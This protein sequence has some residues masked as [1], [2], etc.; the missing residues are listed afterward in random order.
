LAEHIAS[1]KHLQPVAAPQSASVATKTKGGRTPAWKLDPNSP[2]AIDYLGKLDHQFEE[3]Q[4]EAALVLNR[5]IVPVHRY[6]MAL[7]GFSANMSAAEASAL[8]SVPGVVSVEK[9]RLHRIHTDA[10]PP[11]IGAPAIWNGEGFI[12]ES[13]GEGIVV[14]IIDTGINWE[15]GSFADTGENGGYDYENPYPGQLG[16]CSEEEVECNDKLVGVWDFVEDDPDTDT[17]E[18]FNNGFDNVNH[19]TLVAHITAGNPRGVVIG[20]APLTLTGVAQRAH[21][22]SYR[23]C[24]VGDP[25]EDL[26]QGSAILKAI[27]QAID[28]GVDVINYSIGSGAFSP[29]TPGSTARAFL[30]A[31]DAG[32]FVATSS[33]NDG[34]A[35]YTVGSPGNAPW[36]TAVGSATHDRLLA[37]IVKATNG[38]DTTPPGDLY[39]TSFVSEGVSLTDIVHAKDFGFPLCGTGPDEDGFSCDDNTGASNPWEPGTFNGEIVVCDRGTYGRVEKGKNLMLAGAGGYILANTSAHG[40]QIDTDSHC[41]P[42]SHIGAEDADR[43]RDWLDSGDGHMGSIT[44]FTYINR[45][46]VADRLSWF[47]SR[48]P[49]L[50]PVQNILKPDIIAPGDLIIGAGNEGQ[51]LGIA[52]GTSFSSPHV[53][54]AAAL[55]KSLDTSMTPSMLSSVLVTTSTMELAKDEFDNPGTPHQFGGG[56]PQLGEAAQAGVYFR[57]TTGRFL[58]ANPSA[59]GNP[60]TLNLPTMTNAECIETCSFT[61]TVRPLVNNRTWTASTEGFPEGVT[62]TVT[63]NQFVLGADASQE[64]TVDVDLGGV[65]GQWVFG[66]VVLSANN[67]PSAEL[68]VTVM[69]PA[70]EL[71][72]QWT[73]A[74]NRDSGWKSFRL[75]GL[76]G[77]PEA[78]YK[79]SGLVAPTVYSE[80]LEEDPTEGDPYDEGEGVFTEIVA[81]PQGALWLHVQTLESDHDDLDLYVG[82]DDNGN[83]KADPGEER[84]FSA[85]PADLEVCDVMSPQPGNWWVLTQVWEDT[86]DLVNCHEDGGPECVEAEA[87]VGVAVVGGD[88]SSNFNATGP[89]IVPAGTGFDVRLSW[90]DINALTDTTLFGAVSLG[91][92]QDSPGNLGVVPV[93]FTRSGLGAPRTLALMDGHTHAFAVGKNKTY[94]KAFIDVPM[95]ATSLDVVVSG[96]DADQNDRLTLELH[97]MPFEEAFGD[98]PF[99]ADLPLPGTPAGSET[100]SGG[101]GPSVTVS[102]ILLE[103]GRWYAVVTS[104]G[105]ASSVEL[106]AT[107]TFAGNPLPLHPGVWFPFSR[108]TISQGYDYS[109]GGGDTTRVMIWYTYGDDHNSTWYLGSN[110]TPNGNIWTADVLRFTNNGVR[111]QATVVGKMSIS[112]LEEGRQ[113]FSWMLFGESGFDT[114]QPLSDNT[115]PMIGNSRKSYSGIFY[116]GLDGLGGGSVLV[117]ST[118]QAQIHYIYGDNGSP[119]WMIAADD[120]NQ[121][122]T[123]ETL[124][125]LQF[126]GF[127]P[128]C[129]GSV[130]N[131]EVGTV[132]RTFTNESE[133]SWTLDYMLMPP[134]SGDVMRTEDIFKLTDR[135]QCKN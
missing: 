34:P 83:G 51:S 74:S 127:C 20:S 68:P 101:V 3:F 106:T 54:G 93:Y 65:I 9:E 55:L 19:G 113:V 69:S 17:I 42:S 60:E 80:L 35:D 38:G 21:I 96:A 24:Y 23:V 114:M 27:D 128:T 111:Q 110:D 66:N 64:I 5:K 8:A 73:I 31:F 78:T 97:R 26:C 89:G 122:P 115:C 82:R 135:F 10:G 98:A 129:T 44:G 32:I 36:I 46:D 30:N 47:S 39:G 126:S 87:A 100:G 92:S 4:A 6:R 75:N 91:T 53:A 28:D 41:L 99:A 70:G 25:P 29:W 120:E 124:P 59:G 112:I 71:P 52:G 119:N 134:L 88:E 117:N 86:G 12:P 81:V 48:G 62:V 7:N 79:A 18:E 49:N 109:P 67:L 15:H 133:G 95:G 125:M 77:M 85:D 45:D 63:P 104:S 56:R 11:W 103:P 102:G 50:A 40:E 123:A 76:A 130:S 132:T 121:S 131:D 105:G 22:V 33:G 14:G 90:N 58:A 57:E 37:S 16:L 13:F 61:R 43:L 72:S 118:A 108:P 94:D 2:A 116:R 84:C 107:V 1:N